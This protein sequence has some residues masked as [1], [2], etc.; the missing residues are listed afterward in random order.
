MLDLF[1]FGFF[2]DNPE[3]IPHLFVLIYHIHVFFEKWFK[4]VEFHNMISY[5]KGFRE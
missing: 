1:A 3:I 2:V 4:S 5:I